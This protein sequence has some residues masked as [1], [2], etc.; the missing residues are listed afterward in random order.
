MKKTALFILLAIALAA[1]PIL[2]ACKAEPAPAPTPAPAPEEPIELKF[3]LF[4]PEKSAENVLGYY[5]YGQAIEEATK[6]KVKVTFY[7]GATLLSPQEAYDGVIAGIADMGLCVL[8]HFPGRFP[9]CEVF[10]MPFLGGLLAKERATVSWRVYEKFPE[11]QAHFSDVHLLSFFDTKQ[12]YFLS[13]N[14]IKTLEDAKGVRIRGFP[15]ETE[16]S[17]TALGFSVVMMPAP[18]IYENLQKGVID[19]TLSAW[20]M[21]TGFR[22]NEVAKYVF[23]MQHGGTGFLIPMNLDKWNSLPADIQNQITSVSGG[24]LGAKFG[25]TVHDKY[26]DECVAKVDELGIIYTVP[27]PEEVARWR[28]VGGTD[29]WNDWAARMDAKGLPGRE[30]LDYTIKVWEED[31]GW[32]H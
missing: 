18:E 17:L 13:K 32:K 11:M 12:S 22:L 9:L 16:Q 3:H 31:F 27:T 10:P 20:S 5:P 26:A 29:I 1:V 28:E 4:A 19:A 14:P 21:T 24:T 25:D 7:P 15:G 23:D 30:V 2:G 8:T 6:G